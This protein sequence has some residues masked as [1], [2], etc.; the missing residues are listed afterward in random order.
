MVLRPLKLV[1]GKNVDELKA[2]G[3]KDSIGSYRQNSAYKSARRLNT[4]R[5]AVRPALMRLQRIRTLLGTG[6][7]IYSCD[8]LAKNLDMSAH[9]LKV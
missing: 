9:V 7:E 3:L 8:I 5:Q 2:M 4:N 6:F 1:C